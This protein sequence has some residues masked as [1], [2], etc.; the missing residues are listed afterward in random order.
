MTRKSVGY[1]EGTDSTLL[2]NLVINGYDTVPISNGSDRHGMSIT[3]I[4]NQ[5]RHAL[6]MGYVHKICAQKG[7]A[8]Q[9][10]DVFH[11]CRTYSIPLLLVVPATMHD[12]IRDR[13]PDAPSVVELLD[14][15]DTLDRALELLA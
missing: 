15:A 12:S 6:L 1:F 14:P 8:I 10:Q 4:D 9:A 13:L 7:D 2:T 5:N 3:R 11:I